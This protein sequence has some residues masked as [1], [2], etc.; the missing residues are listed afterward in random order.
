MQEASRYN[1]AVPCQRSL[2]EARFELE[3]NVSPGLDLGDLGLF[4]LN[5]GGIVV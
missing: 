4:R 3:I 2:G 5:A 1:D